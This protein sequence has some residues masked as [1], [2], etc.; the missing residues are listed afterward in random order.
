MNYKKFAEQW[1]EGAPDTE[2]NMSRVNGLATAIHKSFVSWGE[3][4]EI[5]ERC[6]KKIP[7]LTRLQIDAQEQGFEYE[8]ARLRGKLEG[9][10]LVLSYLLEMETTNGSLETD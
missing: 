4:I 1:Y 7:I 2:D 3:I 10:E 9:L 6:E 8:N 5:R